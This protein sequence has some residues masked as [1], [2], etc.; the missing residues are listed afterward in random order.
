MADGLALL[1]PFEQGV[2]DARAKAFID[3]GAPRDLAHTVAALRPLTATTDIADLAKAA[4]WE[5]IPTA[6]LYHAVGETFGFD[7]L[8]AAA[9]SIG[10]GDP[11]E[12]Q[13]VRELIL[14][15]VAEQ[16]ARVRAV[17]ALAKR[18]APDVATVIGGWV[19]PR[20]GAVNRARAVI[21]DIEQSA[22]GWSFAKLT[23]ANVA[24]KAASAQAMG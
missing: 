21:D 3:A 15:M 6:K 16:T 13:A 7:R 11:Y 14:D 19:E 24:L 4:K 8:R 23:I 5:T 17:M 18:P 10:G 9:T 2:V 22:G 20:K 12:R 1:S